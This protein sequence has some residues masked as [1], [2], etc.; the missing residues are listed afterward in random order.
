MFELYVNWKM[1][2]EVDMVC[3][4]PAFFAVAGVN[5]GNASNYLVCGAR[6]KCRT[7]EIQNWGGNH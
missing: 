6:V 5:C 4:M 2:K 3:T 1:R 7:S